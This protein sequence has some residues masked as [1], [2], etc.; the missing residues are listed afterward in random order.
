MK[1]MKEEKVIISDFFIG[2]KF[3]MSKVIAIIK[4]IK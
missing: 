4:S 2:D 3:K 1:K